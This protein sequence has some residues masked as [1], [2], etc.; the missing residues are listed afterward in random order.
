MAYDETTAER[1]RHLLADRPDFAEKKMMGGIAFMVK[2]GMCCA[3]SGR[4][5]LLV[6]VGPD[7]AATLVKEPHVAP[8]RMAGRIVKTYVRVMPEAY[9][10]PAQL[11][12]WIERG[13]AFTTSLPA[14]TKRASS[15]ARKTPHPRPG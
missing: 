10:T 9:R 6:R 2:G 5:G 4:G 12:K 3:A 7:A 1:I 11:R 13:V 8:M 14:K 15:A